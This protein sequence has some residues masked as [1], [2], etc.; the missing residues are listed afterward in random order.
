MIDIVKQF[1]KGTFN[2]EEI[3]KLSSN[4][5][6]MDTAI[7]FIGIQPL[8]FI[9]SSTFIA[10]L[11][12]S[13]TKSDSDEVDKDSSAKYG[14]LAIGGVF[15][16]VLLGFFKDFF[17]SVQRRDTFEEVM[18]VANKKADSLLTKRFVTLDQQH[19]AQ[20]PAQSPP[21]GQPDGGAVDGGAGGDGQPGGGAVGATG[22]FG[23]GVGQHSVYSRPVAGDN[24]YTV[25]PAPAQSPFGGPGGDASHHSPS[26]VDSVKSSS[27]Q[28]DTV[29]PMPTPPPNGKYDHEAMEISEQPNAPHFLGASL[30]AGGHPIGDTSQPTSIFSPE[31]SQH[32]QVLDQQASTSSSESKA[33]SDAAGGDSQSRADSTSAVRLGRTKY[34]LP[35]T[36]SHAAA[37]APRGTSPGDIELQIMDTSY[38]AAE[39]G[40]AGLHGLGG[41]VNTEAARQLRRVIGVPRLFPFDGTVQARPRTAEIDSS[42]VQG[43]L[44]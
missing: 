23:G 8:L 2:S 35:A 36:P 43:G 19:A 5:Y 42:T 15:F 32:P 12:E 6:K 39:G 25:A 40:G 41:P 18:G 11:I 44:M 10:A 38:G 24:A 22:V 1:L 14:G 20:P 26:P 34:V 33:G 29:H 28:L 17:L 30:V 9:L 7:P 27:Q 13:L 4:W 3:K 31:A 37:G 16:F 21:G